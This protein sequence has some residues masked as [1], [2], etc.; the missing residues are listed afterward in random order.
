MANLKDAL[1]KNVGYEKGQFDIKKQM[2]KKTF[3]GDDFLSSVLREKLGIEKEKKAK[4][5]SK[6]GSE[7]LG[8]E[9]S[10]VL[11]IIAKNTMVLSGMAKDVKNLSQNIQKLVK[12]KGGKST[13]SASDFFRKQKDKTAGKLKPGKSKSPTASVGKKVASAAPSGIMDILGNIAGFIGGA[14]IEVVKSLFN[15]MMIIRLL[16][17]LALPLLIVGTLVS[18]IMAGWKKYQETG[19]FTDS[20]V[21]YF[22]GMLEFL[23]LGLFGED[24]LK[25]VLDSLGEIF[26][27][28]TDSVSKIFDSVKGFFKNIFGNLIKE[29]VKPPAAPAA[30]QTSMDDSDDANA[31]EFVPPTPSGDVV[32]KTVEE[33]IPKG[34]FGDLEGVAKAG[35]GGDFGAMIAAGEEFKKKYPVKAPTPP[36]AAPAPPSPVSSSPPSAAPTPV[37][38]KSGGSKSAEL[39]AQWEAQ[40]LVVKQK[41]VERVGAMKALV[42][43]S[44]YRN[45]SEDEKAKMIKSGPAEEARIAFNTE[46]QKLTKLAKELEAAKKSE[47]EEPIKTEGATGGPVTTPTPAPPPA[48]TAPTAAAGD[49]DKFADK[50]ESNRLGALQ[51][52]KRSLGIMP[53]DPRKPE[54]GFTDMKNGDKALSEEEVRKR[55]S[56]TGK[57]PDKILELLKDTG[58]GGGS[59]DLRSGNLNT[60][61]GGAIGGG[62]GSA[63]GGGV[64]AGGGGGGGGTAPSVTPSGGGASSGAAISS[65]SSEVAEGQRMESAADKGATISAGTTNNSSGSTGK[66]NKQ[67]ASAYDDSFAQRLAAS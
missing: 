2:A 25:G 55:I 64:S 44:A 49:G 47:N 52:M 26:K 51:F 28:V 48:P 16:S 40:Y 22:G 42:E 67:T 4:S 66:P 29:D 54:S 24:Q 5:P 21:S 27:P 9:A 60:I 1:L 41:N 18:G 56:A 33:V 50:A 17:K 14:L 58:K 36:P 3:G 34:I 62:A 61:T 38:S 43:S 15:P 10:S 37:S 6:E 11:T 30:P 45:A 13:S 46:N 35:E 63:G 53:P 23:T 31:K 39:D 59:I 19:S 12:L 20:I 8:A 57:N 32:N 7:G 65:A